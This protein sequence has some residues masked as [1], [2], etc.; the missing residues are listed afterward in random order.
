MTPFRFEHVYRASSP[1]AVFATYF[2]PIHAAEEDRR[3]GVASREL[4]EMADRPDELLR[5]SCVRPVRQV[6]AVLRPLVGSDL[7]YDE[8]VVWHKKLDRIDYDIRPRVLSGR[9]HVVATYQLT[10][11]GAGQVRR[12]YE[13]TVT[14]ELRLIGGRVERGI[15]EDIG[16]SLEITAAC[17]Q[18]AID[19]AA[20]RSTR[21]PA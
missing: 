17:T 12:V 11:E 15:I 14:A 9:I 6:P 16:R 13:G 5:V 4:L 18:E 2:D 3:A 1:A 19:K 7:S 21:P 10:Q 8:T 20:R